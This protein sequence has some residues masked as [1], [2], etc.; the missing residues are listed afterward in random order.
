MKEVQPYRD[1][2]KEVEVWQAHNT[3][4]GV[5]PRLQARALF[6][7]LQGMPRQIVLSELSVAELTAD[8]GVTNIVNTLDVFC[9]GN[10]TQHAFNVIDELMTCKRDK[11]SSMQTL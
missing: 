7:S 11:D 1:W 6:Q 5:A 10:K 9:M 2:R 3:G 8:D 4:L